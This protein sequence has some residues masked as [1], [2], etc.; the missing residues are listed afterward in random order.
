MMS[1]WGQKQKFGPAS[2]WV[3]S[4]PESWTSKAS[5]VRSALGQEPTSARKTKFHGSPL[6]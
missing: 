5:Y 4:T 2:R 6:N 1:G 3:R